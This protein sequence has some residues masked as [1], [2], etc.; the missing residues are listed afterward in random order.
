MGIPAYWPL[1]ATVIV[2]IAIIPYISLQLQAISTSIQALVVMQDNRPWYQ[3]T[4]LYVT[5]WLAVFALLFSGRSAKAHQPNP[6][7]MAAI[8]FESLV[9]LLAGAAGGRRPRACVLGGCLVAAWWPGGLPAMPGCH[10][11]PCHLA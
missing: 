4:G 3:D 6:G 1:L 2:L 7:L 8:A 11:M 10:A 5:L 9:K